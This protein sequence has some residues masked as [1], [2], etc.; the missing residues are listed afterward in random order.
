MTWTIDDYVKKFFPDSPAKQEAVKVLFPRRAEETWPSAE[1]IAN[2]TGNS[3]DG[4]RRVLRR[5]SIEP[6]NIVTAQPVTTGGKGRSPLKY[7]LTDVFWDN[8]ST[9]QME[10]GTPHSLTL[11]SAEEAKKRRSISPE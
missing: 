1:E 7:G 3:T 9:R 8:F 11:I 2:L 10:V 5:L 4:A 6:D